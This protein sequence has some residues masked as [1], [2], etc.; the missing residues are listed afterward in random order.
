MITIY[1]DRSFTFELKSP[2][3]AVPAQEGRQDRQGLGR[4]EPREGGEVTS[5]QLREIAEMKMPDLNANDIEAGDE[6]HRGHRPLDGNRSGGLKAMAGIEASDTTKASD[7][8][9]TARGY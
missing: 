3:A 7:G 8:G 6:D 2:P 9:S 5:R 1:A 4:A